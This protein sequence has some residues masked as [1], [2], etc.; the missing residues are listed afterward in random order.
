M[1]IGQINWRIVFRVIGIGSCPIYV[2]LL[3]L[4]AV[5]FRGRL[6]DT[7]EAEN[8]RQGLWLLLM[9]SPF[10]LALLLSFIVREP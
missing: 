10:V 2:P 7:S 4:A 8:F 6:S 9:A 5:A 1:W 3:L